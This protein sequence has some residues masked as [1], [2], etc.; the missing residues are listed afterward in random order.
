VAERK[1][2]PDGRNSITRKFKIPYI[3]E[4]GKPTKL[5]FYAT[6]GLYD[7]G[8]PG[9]IFLRGD[10]LGGFIAG[11]FDTLATTIS[12]GLQHGVPLKTLVEKWRW[13]KFEP[14]GLTPKDPDFRSCTSA[15]DL[16]AQW[17]QLKF[18]KE[19]NA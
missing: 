17:L 15:A 2:L 18:I 1:R 8:Q 7:D 13:S 19:G 9:E 16:I 14:S 12:L 3:G 11:I 10:K 5:K 4:D 6:V